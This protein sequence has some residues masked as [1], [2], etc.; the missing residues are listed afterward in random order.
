MHYTFLEP[1]KL[2][3]NAGG[4]ETIWVVRGSTTRLT[5]TVKGEPEIHVH[6]THDSRP[7]ALQ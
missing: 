1:P 4:G 2:T 6:W 3:R 7:L 5:C